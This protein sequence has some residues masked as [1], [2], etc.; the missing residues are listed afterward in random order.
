MSVDCEHASSYDHRRS[1]ILSVAREVFLTEGFSA[2][3][4]SSIACRVG[5]SKGTLYRYFPSKADLFKAVVQKDCD[6]YEKVLF[7]HLDSTEEDIGPALKSF[8]HRYSGVVLSEDVIRLNRH[9]IAEAVRFPDLARVLYDAGPQ[10]SRARLADY[11]AGQTHLGRLTCQDPSRA[12]YQFCQM[13]LGA[14]YR[15][16]L[17]NLIAAASPVEAEQDLDYAVQVFLA[18]HGVKH[19]HPRN[20]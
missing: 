1:K 10:R 16:R 19:A 5:G 15:Q 17:M 9:V 3:S 4:M 18:T 12:A 14:Q 2:S 6:L 8:G 7:D 11:I 20:F 13:C